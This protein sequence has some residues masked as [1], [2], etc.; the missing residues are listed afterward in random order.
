MVVPSGLQNGRPAG[1]LDT[2]SHCCVVDE[3]GGGVVAPG[4]SLL[5]QPPW[6]W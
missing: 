5:R 6:P 2:E 3:R 4:G 1:W